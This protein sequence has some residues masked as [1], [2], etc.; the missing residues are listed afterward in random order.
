MSPV[1]GIGINLAIQDAVCTANIL[2][3]PMARR[4]QVD[5]LLPR[6]QRRRMLPTRAIQGAQ[7]AVHENLLRPLLE[8]RADNAGPPPLGLRLLDRFPRLRRIPGWLIGHGVRQEH[9]R[10]L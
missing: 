4:W 6:I 5:D 1:G 8:G 7:R 9:V 3:G 2:A 10:S